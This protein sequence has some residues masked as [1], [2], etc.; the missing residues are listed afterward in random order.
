VSRWLK[1]VGDTVTLNEPLVEI[2][3]DKVDTEIPSP[4]AGVLLEIRVQEDESATVGT[5]LAIIGDAPVEEKVEEKKP[6]KDPTG[7]GIIPS[8]F[9][10]ELAPAQI[11]G[12]IEAA[13]YVTPLVRKLAEE[14]GVDLALIEGSGVGGRVRKQDVL[15]KAAAQP[16]R[17]S[18]PKAAPAPIS[19]T[20]IVPAI[21]EVPL[22]TS[23]PTPR[24]RH[25][26]PK[27]TPPATPVEPR[28]PRVNSAPA[29][30]YAATAPTPSPDPVIDPAEL[31]APEPRVIPEP[32]EVSESLAAP[33][34]VILPEVAVPAPEPVKV[35]PAPLVVAPEPIVSLPP[36]VA[37]PEPVV[38]EPVV[39]VAPLPPVPPVVVAPAP[40]LA[41]VPR[42]ADPT[43]PVP[44]GKTEKMSRLQATIARQ[45]VESLL[46]SAQ[47]T[48]T[49][50]VDLTRIA[51]ER[52]RL[53]GVFDPQ[54]SPTLSYLPFIAKATVEALHE[55]PRVNATIDAD[56]EEITYPASE[57][58][59]ITID[60]PRGQLVPVI[61]DAYALS[62]TE[63]A[64][65]IA[66][67]TTRP[68]TAFSPDELMG[69]TFT[70]TNYGESG[71]LFD[72]PII[73]QPQVGILGMGAV[74]RRPIVVDDP[75]LGEVIVVR[76]MVY[77]SLSYDHRLVD[78]GEAARFLQ[79]IKTRLELGDFAEED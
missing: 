14:A 13:P 62:V 70:I 73:S 65:K 78:S 74:T 10:P 35:A 31:Y 75:Q 54:A 12:D 41:P 79:T 69:G 40:K 53:K 47:L 46:E 61:K 27:R 3:S 37:T 71:T 43:T 38:V 50:E 44:R 8:P 15:T 4:I 19:T 49:V 72:T 33:D 18:E 36:I 22:V 63:L 76:N 68:R 26:P 29:W 42:K 17:S 66:D 16:R 60:T 30:G 28:S 21:P 25:V 5:V 57:N 45:T 2:S 67:I 48:A 51:K 24:V 1:R 39:I 64:T 34:L 59:G 52:D 32:V 11:A 7:L 55:F 58:L 77:L 56:A 6:L 20:P 23:T 9:V